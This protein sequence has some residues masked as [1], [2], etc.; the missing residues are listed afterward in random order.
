MRELILIILLL[1]EYRRNNLLPRHKRDIRKRTLTTHEPRPIP[2]ASPLRQNP[3][4]DARHAVHF[5]DVARL[6]AG[7]L[8]GVVP[9]EPDRLAVIGALARDL[10]E[11]PLL[12]V[13]GVRGAGGEAEAVVRVV[14]LDEVFDD[15]AR[16]PEGEVGVGVVDGG[17]A[18][19][20]VAGEVVWGFDVG[21]GG[22]GYVVGE[23]EF[24]E[25]DGD[26]A[27]VGA[28]LAPD[29]DGFEGCGHFE[30]GVF[31]FFLFCPSFG[32]R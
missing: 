1:R 18:A 30:V 31:F 27:G 10:E 3:L 17:E 19:V 14:A 24:F 20:G 8:F 4:Q 6:G 16:F 23:V 12:G 28:A 13:V 9:L 22:C 32:C 15:G 21:E 2:A 7:Q 26:F 11:E 25:Q 5:G 29:V